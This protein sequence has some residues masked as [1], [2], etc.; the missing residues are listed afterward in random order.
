MDVDDNKIEEWK[1]LGGS[2]V[3]FNCVTEL[4]KLKVYQRA[5]LVEHSKEVGLDRHI[6]YEATCCSMLTVNR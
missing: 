4:S 2:S 3:S 5:G 1:Q 6:I